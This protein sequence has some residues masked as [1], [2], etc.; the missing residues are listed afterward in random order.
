MIGFGL[1]QTVK[2]VVFLVLLLVFFVCFDR[3]YN[4]RYYA[5]VEY[6]ETLGHTQV[7]SSGTCAIQVK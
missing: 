7:S 4:R 3:V 5:C 1:S 2:C 6:L